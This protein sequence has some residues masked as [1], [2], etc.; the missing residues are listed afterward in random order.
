MR[1]VSAAEL[2]VLET[3]KVLKNTYLLLSATLG[4]SALTALFSMSLNI[5]GFMPLIMMIGAMVLGMFVLPKT[6]NSSAGIGV[7]FLITGMLGFAIGPMLNTYLGLSNGSQVVLTALGGTAAIFVGL[8]AYAVNSKKDF[9]F[10]GGMLIGGMITVFVLII[11][12]IFLQ[13]PGLQLLIS[14]AVIM[15]MS[16]FI[17]MDTSRIV[18][19]GETNYILATFGMY[20][21][22]FNIFIHLLAILGIMSE[23]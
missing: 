22:I 4:F 9:S 2:S 1:S 23:D 20:L 12:N 6:A 14:G 13:M 7:I 15:L 5:G 3:N 19:G 21:S 16:G 18:L 17:L 10:M 8:S 11:A